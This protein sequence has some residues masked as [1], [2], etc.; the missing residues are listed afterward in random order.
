MSTGWW[1]AG[2]PSPG[3]PMT[4]RASS[5]RPEPWHRRTSGRTSGP[6]RVSGPPVLTHVE[7]KRTDV[8]AIP[9]VVRGGRPAHHA[10]RGRGAGAHARFLGGAVAV[11]VPRWRG[12]LGGYAPGP[13]SGRGPGR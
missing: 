13:G 10:H 2:W 9:A 3:S 11:A 4:S 8:G 7:R 1:T 5:P 6:D 12:V